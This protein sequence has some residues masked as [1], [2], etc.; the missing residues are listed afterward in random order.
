MESLGSNKENGV[1]KIPSDYLFSVKRRLKIGAWSSGSQTLQHPTFLILFYTFY[2]LQFFIFLKLLTD[3]AYKDTLCK[4]TPGPLEGTSCP[5]PGAQGGPGE[6][7][8]H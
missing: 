1:R 6:K 3:I 2:S 7:Q 8:K 4:N 5:L